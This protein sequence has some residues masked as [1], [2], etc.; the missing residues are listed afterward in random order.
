MDLTSDTI[1]DYGREY[2]KPQYYSENEFLED[3]RRLQNIKK[4]IHKHY[5]SDKLNERL[6]LNHLTIIFNVFNFQAA[7]NMIFFT[8]PQEYYPTIKTF[9]L[10]MNLITDSFLIEIPLDQEVIKVLRK[11]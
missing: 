8:L 11:L 1:E 7:L 2:Y 5:Y 10:Y 3:L 9:L 4:L 6:I